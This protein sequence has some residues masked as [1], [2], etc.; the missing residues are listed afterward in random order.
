MGGASVGKDE[1]GNVVLALEVPLNI[2]LTPEE[3]I[4]LG[5]LLIEVA[6][7]EPP[8]EPPPYR[9]RF[10]LTGEPLLSKRGR[11]DRRRG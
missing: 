9:K 10:A 1:A 3:A 4:A 5:K 2:G 7:G 8:D 6:G 11:H